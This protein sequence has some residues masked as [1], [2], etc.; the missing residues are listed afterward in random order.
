MKK[1]TIT[2][3]PE[4]ANTITCYI[5]MTTKHRQE[6]RKACD[7]LSR[8]LTEDGTMKFP[9]MVSNARFWEKTEGEL[10]KIRKIIDNGKWSDCD[11]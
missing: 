8:I 7:E 10:A 2:L 5:L 11:D 6:E 1:I 4:Q 9:N 3:T